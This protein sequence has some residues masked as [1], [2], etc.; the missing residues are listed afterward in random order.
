MH[1][2]IGRE[3]LQVWGRKPHPCRSGSR[4]TS[5]P[6]Q[7]IGT[8]S[9]EKKRSVSGRCHGFCSRKVH[10]IGAL[11]GKEV[12]VESADAP[13][14]HFLLSLTMPLAVALGIVGANLTPPPWNILLS[15]IGA[16]QTLVVLPILDAIVGQEGSSRPKGM[17][18]GNE[19][20]S[21]AYRHVLYVYAC[22]HIL[23]LATGIL[24]TSRLELLPMVGGVLSLGVMGGLGYTTVHELVHGRTKM[25]HTLASIMLSFMWAM[26]WQRSHLMHHKHVGK[27]EDPSTAR[28]GENFYAFALR[29]IS[30][31]IKNGLEDAQARGHPNAPLCWIACPTTLACMFVLLGGIRA[32]FV[33]VS[34]ACVAAIILETVNYIQHYGLERKRTPGGEYEPYSAKHSWNANWKCSN[35]FAFNLQH[36]AEHHLHASKPYH[37]LRNVEGAP[38]LPMSYPLLM[39][40]SLAPPLFRRVMDKELSE[41]S[42]ASCINSSAA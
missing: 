24:G 38:K 27:R 25:E 22:T 11:T 3:L 29:S 31:N 35:A 16:L 18:Q 34:Q 1:V 23:V 21:A 32:G 26:H 10:S 19:S 17:P 37:K 12:A 40:L 36:H 33:F 14:S 2:A 30:G 41:L 15:S 13:A 39:M 5:L 7:N 9:W 42:Q 20:H 6:G 8:R 28:K 4:T